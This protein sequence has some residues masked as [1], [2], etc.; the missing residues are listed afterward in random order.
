MHLSKYLAC[1]FLSA[2]WWKITA[3]AGTSLKKK[4]RKKKRKEETKFLLV[5]LLSR[6]SGILLG[7]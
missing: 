6:I 1:M 3:L 2:V 4:K 7:R 5:K